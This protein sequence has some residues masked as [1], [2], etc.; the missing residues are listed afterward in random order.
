MKEG[1]SVA[2]GRVLD[3]LE[4]E[5]LDAPPEEIAEVVAATGMTLPVLVTELRMRTGLLA[6]LRHTTQGA[7]AESEEMAADQEEQASIGRPPN[8]R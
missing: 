7:E 1:A 8:A 4:T 5:L 3:A 2:L 6:L